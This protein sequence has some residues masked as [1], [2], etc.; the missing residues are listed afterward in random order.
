MK[1]SAAA[2]LWLVTACGDAN[3]APGPADGSSQ[4]VDAFG[5]PDEA[6][7]GPSDATAERNAAAD[8]GDSTD[9]GLPSGEGGAVTA[10]AGA[11]VPPATLSCTG[12][13]ADIAD[14]A[15][16]TLAPGVRSY[17]PAVPLYSSCC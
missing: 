2:A 8:A 16:K 10:C 17:Q 3:L 4:V 7:P 1:K 11:T 6:S 12:L 13:Y 15:T 5:V 14:I 9:A